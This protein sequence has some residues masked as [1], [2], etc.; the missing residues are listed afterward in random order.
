M[1]RSVYLNASMRC[2]VCANLVVVD[3]ILFHIYDAHF[4]LYAVFKTQ[5]NDC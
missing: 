5:H 2:V 1:F 3:V 4:F